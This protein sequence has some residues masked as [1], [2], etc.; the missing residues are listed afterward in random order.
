M[1]N[2]QIYFVFMHILLNFYINM[3]DFALAFC[4]DLLYIN[5]GTNV[6]ES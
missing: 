3:H 4:I 2:M 6:S 1:H 5:L